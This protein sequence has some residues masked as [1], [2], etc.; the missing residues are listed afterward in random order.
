MT[1]YILDPAEDPE[2][3]LDDFMSELDSELK[4]SAQTSSKPKA[5]KPQTVIELPIPQ[6]WFPSALIFINVQSVC[7]C[8]GNVYESPMGLFMEDLTKNGASRLT[9]KKAKEKIPHAYATLPQHVRLEQQLVEHCSACFDKA[10]VEFGEPPGLDELAPGIY[11]AK[12]AGVAEIF[13]PSR[14]NAVELH[15]DLEV[16]AAQEGEQP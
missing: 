1:T 16:G 8:C 12:I 14:P 7:T 6:Q 5:R 13:D 2:R 10:I 9:R 11:T 4:R 15:I 3:E